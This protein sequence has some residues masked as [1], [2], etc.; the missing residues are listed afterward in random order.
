MD[1][2]RAPAWLPAVKYLVRAM[3]LADA[4]VLAAEALTLGT[5]KEIYSRCEAFYR[6][7]VKVE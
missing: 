3:T 6:A 2:Y 7:R 1:R 5:P 4:R